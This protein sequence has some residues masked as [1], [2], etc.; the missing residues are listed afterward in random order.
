MFYIKKE[1]VAVPAMRRFAHSWYSMSKDGVRYD[2]KAKLRGDE[3]II[4]VT[5]QA[6][7]LPKK[8]VQKII[9]L[10]NNE[11]ETLRLIFERAEITSRF[12]NVL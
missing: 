10:G 12:K 6:V 2:K 9:D 3:D 5:I 7:S 11:Q 8:E 4:D 1:A